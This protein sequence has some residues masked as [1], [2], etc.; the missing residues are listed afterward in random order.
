M[1]EAEKMAHE[2]YE[3]R[4]LMDL[5]IIKAKQKLTNFIKTYFKIERRME[6]DV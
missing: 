1:S 4:F 6:E 2:L 3:I 5:D